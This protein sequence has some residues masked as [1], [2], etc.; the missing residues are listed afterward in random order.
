M[1]G[2]VWENTVRFYEFLPKQ[3][4][5]LGCIFFFAIINCVS[6]VRSWQFQ[7]SIDL[8]FQINNLVERIWL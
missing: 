8:I 5:F 1:E 3:C 6:H 2:V 4:G 7:M